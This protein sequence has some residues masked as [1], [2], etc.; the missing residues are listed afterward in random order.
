METLEHSLGIDADALRE[1]YR[2]ERNKRLRPEGKRQYLDI[3]GRFAHY[4]DDPWAQPDFTRA[5][6]SEAFNVIIVGGGL[7]G[8]LAGASLRKQGIDNIRIV[9]RGADFGGA[10]Y[11]N[12]YPGA[13]CDTQAMLY[14]PMLEET[15]YRPERKFATGPELREHWQR[16]AERFDLYRDAC[17]QTEVTSVRWDSE[18]A[19][20]IVETNRDD[21]MR[22][23]FLIIAQGTIERPKLPGIEGI[24][25][26]A[27][28]SFHTSRWD[29]QYTGGNETGGLGGLA[30]KSV[31]IIGTGATA[32]QCIP[33][34]AGS[35]K[36][37]YIFQRTPSSIDVRGDDVLDLRW[38][39][40]M[41]PG[42]Q[43]HLWENFTAQTSGI[44]TDDDL[45]RDGWTSVTANVRYLVEQKRERGESLANPLELYQL[46]DYMKMEEIRS[47][48]GKLVTDPATA[49][50]LKPWY[51]RFCKRPAFSDEYLQTFNRSNVTLV[52]A[53]ANQGVDRISEDAVIVSGKRYP[54]DCLIFSTGFAIDNAP[55]NRLGYPVRGRDGVLLADKWADGAS[56]LHGIATHGF[57][58]LFLMSPTQSGVSLNFTHMIS[59]QANHIAFILAHA[60]A[61][62]AAEV[63]VTLQAEQAWVAEVQARALDDEVF[64]RECTPSYFNFEGDLGRRNAKNNVFGGGPMLFYRILEEWRKTAL[65]QDLKFTK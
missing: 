58:N 4:G 50:L 26:F 42:W 24:G 37:L 5:P 41:G 17:F 19:Q 2:A 48:V 34:L 10:W 13:A 51:N 54:V 39:E 65:T 22:A 32:I 14:M 25:T 62:E 7:G 31:G 9:E 53:V 57:P 61:H 45:I 35:A 40:D 29:Y 21:A 30:E 55:T 12:R 46:A 6:S 33:H 18:N 1:R 11:W 59:E 15:G 56:T 60:A 47:R 52:D 49:E 28:H 44:L 63:E 20:W 16:I 64:Q 36:H 43:R 27:G 8:L 38:A 3:G 23:R